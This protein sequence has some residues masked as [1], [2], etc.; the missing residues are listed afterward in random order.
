MQALARE[1]G[2]TIMLSHLVWVTTK[3][4]RYLNVQL[5]RELLACQQRQRN[6]S[7]GC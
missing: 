7:D 4:N 3:L 2:G 6:S 1:R 5:L